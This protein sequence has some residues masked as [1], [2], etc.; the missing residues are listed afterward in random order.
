MVS[1]VFK[2]L[3]KKYWD[4]Y[5]GIQNPVNFMDS[6]FFFFGSMFTMAIYLTIVNSRKHPQ[7]QL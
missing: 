5:K 3:F 1:V 2:I 7:E 4:N 6:F